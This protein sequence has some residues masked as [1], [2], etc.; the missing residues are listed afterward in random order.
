M[1]II[2]IIIVNMPMGLP[3]CPPPA[4]WASMEGSA[5]ACAIKRSDIIGKVCL[6][7]GEKLLPEFAEEAACDGAPSASQEGQI[8]MQ[9]MQG[10]QPQTEDFP[11]LEQVADVSAS[12][13]AAQRMG[14]FINLREVP[15]V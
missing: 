8:E 10:N 11:G 15:G 4:A 2:G 9:I 7:V 6:V 14:V 12:E 3:P 5:T 13:A 1:I